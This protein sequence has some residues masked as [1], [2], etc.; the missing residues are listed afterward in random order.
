MVVVTQ[1]IRTHYRNAVTHSLAGGFVR[2]GDQERRSSIFICRYR[3]LMHGGVKGECTAP[4][5]QQ[6]RLLPVQLR[7]LKFSNR[8]SVTPRCRGSETST[9]EVSNVR[10]DYRLGEVPGGLGD[11]RVIGNAGESLS[12]LRACVR[13]C[14]NRETPRAATNGSRHH[15]VGVSRQS[16]ITTDRRWLRYIRTTNEKPTTADVFG[17]GPDAPSDSHQCRAGSKARN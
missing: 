14:Q 16:L 15:I 6:V 17:G 7:G 4:G 12:R 13:K 9:V 1:S 3:L 2:L 5:L 10:A 11:C 8:R